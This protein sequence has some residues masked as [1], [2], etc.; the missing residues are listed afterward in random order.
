[1]YAC[2]RSESIKLWR[3]HL[4]LFLTVS[5]TMM[6]TELQKNADKMNKKCVRGERRV[7]V[8]ELWTYA[9][10]YS[11]LK[12]LL[13]TKNTSSFF[14]EVYLDFKL[15]I[16][17]AVLCVYFVCFIR[18]L[19]VCVFCFAVEF[20]VV[21]LYFNCMLYASDYGSFGGCDVF[22]IYAVVNCEIYV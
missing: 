19:G 2:S 17:F 9:F 12:H 15:C 14:W 18:C 7:A 13:I 22:S 10:N 6:T 11:V 3:P 20:N 21:F 4:A 5:K 16:N 8:L 1:M